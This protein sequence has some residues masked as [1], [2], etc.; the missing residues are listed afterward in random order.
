MDWIWPQRSAQMNSMQVD[1]QS[2]AQQ[3]AGYE[4]YQPELSSVQNPVYYGIN[5]VLYHAHL[6]RQQRLHH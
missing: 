1:N 3:N 6:E 4:P 2:T 5:E